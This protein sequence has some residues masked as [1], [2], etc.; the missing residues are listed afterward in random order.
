[1]GKKPPIIRDKLKDKIIHSLQIFF[2]AEKEKEGRKER[3]IMK[4]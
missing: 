4:E 2:E 1:M 3:I